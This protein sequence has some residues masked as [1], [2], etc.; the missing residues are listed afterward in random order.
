MWTSVWSL[1][2][3]V[4][5]C[6]AQLSELITSSS[7]QLDPRF[8]FC[9]C[10]LY[11][12]GSS[13]EYTSV[14]WFFL[15]LLL[16]LLLSGLDTAN[17][18]LISSLCLPAAVTDRAEAVLP[19][20][21]LSFSLWLSHT[22]HYLTCSPGNTPAF[23]WGRF[24]SSSSPPWPQEGHFF[25]SSLNSYYSIPSV[26]ECTSLH[27]TPDVPQGSVS[28]PLIFTF[29]MFLMVILLNTKL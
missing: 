16:N 1:T 25:C 26:Q 5:C 21:W 27:A 2:L 22:S 18:I 13:D 7:C 11:F 6:S 4:S 19:K 29:C 9:T 10:H 24:L 20:V 14:F 17:Y 28:G 8:T 3:P 12:T 15:L 23:C